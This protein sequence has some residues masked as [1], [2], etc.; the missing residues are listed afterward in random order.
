MF[1]H[2]LYTS[3]QLLY[4][5]VEQRFQGVVVLQFLLDLLT[6]VD[7]RRVVASAEL[8]SDIWQRCFGQIPAQIHGDLPWH[9]DVLTAPLGL[10]VGNRY[11]EVG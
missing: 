4:Q 11:V 1:F 3:L 9:G 5:A 2:R 8:L 10:Q 6:C 7:D